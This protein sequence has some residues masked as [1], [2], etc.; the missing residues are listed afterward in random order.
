[1]LTFSP[2]KRLVAPCTC[3][4]ITRDDANTIIDCLESALRPGIF[5]R[6]LIVIDTRSEDATGRI[7]HAYS[8]AYPN[9]Q[10]CPYKW[11]D[12]PDFAAARNFGISVSRTPYIFWLDGDEKLV[13]P[14]QIAAMLRDA[15]GEAFMMWII[16]PVAGGFHNMYQPR[17]FP[18]VPGI[19]F[20]CPV[21]ERVDW[22]LK[23]AGVTLRM[24][25]AQPIQHPGYMNA[26]TLAKKNQRNLRIM[27][28]YLREHRQDDEPR[29]H[30]VEQYRKLTGR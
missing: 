10:I 28:G 6:I 13:Q 1:M 26:G 12:P 25:D 4:I 8:Q 23:R 19:R 24:T 18:V 5:E 14:A 27:R 29:R 17:L 9:V 2:G 21:F 7:I 16:S 22:S 20:E 11:S 15:Q 30:I 3:Q